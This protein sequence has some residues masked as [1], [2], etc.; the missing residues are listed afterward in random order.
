MQLCKCSEKETK[1]KK[2]DKNNI[3][4]YV[5]LYCSL[6]LFCITT[7]WMSGLMITITSSIYLYYIIK[8]S[9]NNEKNNCIN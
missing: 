7:M 9:E 3:L 6:S 1:P 4:I 2:I 8:W 5:L